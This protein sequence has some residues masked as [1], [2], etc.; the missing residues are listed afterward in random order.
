MIAACAWCTANHVTAS[1]L[2]H[3]VLATIRWGLLSTSIL[4][5][6]ATSFLTSQQ[7]IDAFVTLELP[8]SALP[9]WMPPNARRPRIAPASGL[10]NIFSSQG[11]FSIP[12]A[13]G[14]SNM[15][16]PVSGMLIKLSAPALLQSFIA[17]IVFGFGAVSGG[18]MTGF[19]TRVS[20]S[21]Q[22]TG[23]FQIDS[24]LASVERPATGDIVAFHFGEDD[25]QGVVLE[26][27]VLYAVLT[28]NSLHSASFPSYPSPRASRFQLH[29]PNRLT[30]PDAPLIEVSGFYR[31]SL[32]PNFATSEMVPTFVLRFAY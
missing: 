4:A 7:C 16:Y 6:H 28:D 24:R 30:L 27:G 3:P 21:S 22:S 31:S 14:K 1:D 10:V 5:K 20:Q 25:S 12:A 32:D 29:E 9:D 2:L 15:H 18:T 17:P 13:F 11:Q 26:P 23:L 19:V 8:D